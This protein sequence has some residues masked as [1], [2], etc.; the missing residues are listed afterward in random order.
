MSPNRPDGS[1]LPLM[2]WG[3]ELRQRKAA[4][5]RL[6]AKAVATGIVCVAV[7]CTALLPSR[8]R[9]VWNATDSAPVGLYRVTPVHPLARG[10]MVIARLTPASARLAAAR[11]YLPFGVP[12]VK[13]IA[14]V[15]GDRICAGTISVSV[16]GRVVATRF[17]VDSRG[18]RLP[19]WRGCV[20]LDARHYLLLNPGRRS[21]DGRYFGPTDAGAIVGLASPLWLH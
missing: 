18:L 21:F 9:F 16:N 14:A 10:D 11:A 4:R 5:H 6:A 2:Q 15:P 20:M 8:P 7:G 1:D 3:N 12:V 19:A 13:R 17:A